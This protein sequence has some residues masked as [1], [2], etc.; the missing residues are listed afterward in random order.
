MNFFAH[1]FINSDLARF[2]GAANRFQA[3]AQFLH[4]VIRKIRR[5]QL[6][7]DIIVKFQGAV[8]VFKFAIMPDARRV[9]R[10]TVKLFLGKMLY[11]V[12]AQR[13]NTPADKAVFAIQFGAVEINRPP[14]LKSGAKRGL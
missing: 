12:I 10:V 4:G 7:P 6:A 3:K 5:R 9:R 11:V 13:A 1:R 14:C 8:F 2:N